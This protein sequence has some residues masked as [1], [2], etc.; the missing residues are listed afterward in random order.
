M[1]GLSYGAG[2]IADL[3]VLG[4]MEKRYRDRWEVLVVEEHL[5]SMSQYDECCGELGEPELVVTVE[6]HT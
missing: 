1:D 4:H 2:S 3:L 6:H 5:A